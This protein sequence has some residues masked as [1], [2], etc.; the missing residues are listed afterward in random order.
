MTE[1]EADKEALA[2]LFLTICHG[3]ERL[4]LIVDFLVLGHV[5][6]VTKVVKVASV[7]LRVQLRNE[8]RTSL[9]QRIP[10]H[11]GK[12]MMVIDILDVVKA[13]CPRVDASIQNAQLVG[14]S[15]ARHMN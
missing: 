3:L 12:V 4:L 11:L 2:H 1:R 8:W 6:L 10:L 9:A 14:G 15:L 7:C 13:A 5:G